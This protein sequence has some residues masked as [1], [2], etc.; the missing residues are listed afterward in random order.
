MV[1]SHCCFKIWD[2]RARAK[3]VRAS[4]DKD[5]SSGHAALHQIVLSVAIIEF[6]LGPRG[7]SLTKP[8]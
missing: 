1:V 6:S 7:V 3:R 2:K 4:S 8:H 5:A